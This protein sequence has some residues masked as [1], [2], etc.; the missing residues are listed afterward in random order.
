MYYQFLYDSYYSFYKYGDTFTYITFSLKLCTV[1]TY[2]MYS[3]SM[4]IRENIKLICQRK[5]LFQGTQKIGL[6]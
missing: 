6:K 4:G 2:T 5:C 1:L 3:E